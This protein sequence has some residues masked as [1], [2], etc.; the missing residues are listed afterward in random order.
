ML[1]F[2]TGAKKPLAKK[3][4][5]DCQNIYFWE[6]PTSTKFSIYYQTKIILYIE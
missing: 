4:K 2:V 3:Y 5:K 1:K 6:S